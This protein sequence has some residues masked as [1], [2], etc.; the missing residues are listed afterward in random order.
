MYLYINISGNHLFFYLQQGFRVEA[1]ITWRLAVQLI[2]QGEK[3]E[4]HLDSETL[5]YCHR[6]SW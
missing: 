5:E 4:K 2:R 3:K 6:D 1:D